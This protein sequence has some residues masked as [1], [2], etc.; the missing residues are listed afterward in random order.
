MVLRERPDEGD[1][2]MKA[3]TWMPMYW[4]DFLADTMHLSARDA[5][6]YV[7]LIANYWQRHGP[8]IDDDEELRIICRCEPANWKRQKETLRR[9]FM[10]KGGLWHHKRIDKELEKAQKLYAERCEAGKIGAKKRWQRHPKRYGKRIA[11]P[12][13]TVKQNDAQPQPQP[14]SPLQSES[15]RERINDANDPLTL[16]PKPQTNRSSLNRSLE[17]EVMSQLRTAL[18]QDEMARCGGHWRKDWVRP[19]CGL[20][21]R[22]LADLHSHIKEGAQIDNPAAWMEDLLKRWD[23]GEPAHA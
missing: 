16:K 8:V 21:Q 6:A 17:N 12:S 15:E 19:K 9:F 3:T 11:K 14:Q 13:R 22:A 18:G 1:P 7:L 20:V 23:N 4:A 2:E 5:G 10:V